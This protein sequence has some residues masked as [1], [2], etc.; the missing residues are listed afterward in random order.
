M[1]TSRSNL[2]QVLDEIMVERPEY[3]KKH[4]HGSKAEQA[5]K[6]KYS[7]SD[8]IRYYW[9]NPRAQAALDLL[10]KNL[11]EK[12]LP[13]SLLSQFTPKQYGKIRRGEIAATPEGIV[14]DHIGE[15]LLDY[16]IACRAD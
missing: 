11:N 4:Y 3:W 10:M 7:L 8:R 15:V 5:L 2:I 14:L 9:T 13:L 1:P 16:E 12:P 6:R